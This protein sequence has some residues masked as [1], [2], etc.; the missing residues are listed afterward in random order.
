MT[1]DELR[2]K[3]EAE[4]ECAGQILA[5][6]IVDLAHFKIFLRAL[7]PADR[8]TAYRTISPYLPFRVPS[9]TLMKGYIWRN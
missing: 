9:W 7:K 8:Q 3:V 2:K 1:T 4:P 6:R 5:E